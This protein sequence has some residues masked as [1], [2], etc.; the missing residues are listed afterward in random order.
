VKLVHIAR[1]SCTQLISR[2]EYTIL[3]D[4]KSK[5]EEEVRF[6]PVNEVSTKKLGKKIKKT[7]EIGL[8]DIFSRGKRTRTEKERPAEK[9]KGEGRHHDKEEKKK[10]KKKRRKVVDVTIEDDILIDSLTEKEKPDMDPSGSTSM[11]EQMSSSSSGSKQ[12]PKLFLGDRTGEVDKESLSVWSQSG[13]VIATGRM[14]QRE[15]KLIMH[16]MVEYF[17]VCSQSPNSMFKLVNIMTSF[18]LMFNPLCPVTHLR[19]TEFLRNMV[20]ECCSIFPL[21]SDCEGSTSIFV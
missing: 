12:R 1:S 20:L 4:G 5:D 2:H 21:M 6:R 18:T 14:R 11:E 15:E 7:K 13:N 3:A 9:S 8:D 17:E 19:N 10:K 16:A